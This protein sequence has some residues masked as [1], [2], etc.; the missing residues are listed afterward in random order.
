MSS[1]LKRSSV[2]KDSE[3]GADVDVARGEISP[4]TAAS[5]EEENEFEVF[6]KTKDG[7]DFRTVGWPRAAVI[8]LKVIFATG[9][10][11]IPTAMY[12]LGAVGGALSV[13]GWGILNTYCAM[14]QGDF[15]NTHAGCHTVADMAG[16]VGGAVIKELC[17]VLYLIAYVLC[18]GSGILGVCIG[19]NSLSHHAA[20]SVWWSFLATCVV[21]VCASVRTFQNVGWLTWAGFISIFTA[22]FI[23]VVGVTTRDRPA[24]APQTGPYDLGFHAIAYPT[25]TAGMVASSTIF[26]SSAGTS[27]FMPVIAEMRKPQDYHKALFTCMGFV[28]VSYLT[29]SLVVY[30]WC[31]QWVASPSLGSAG[32]TIKM[33]SYGVGLIGL[34]VSACLYCHVAAKYLFVRILRNS[35]HLQ[36]NSVIHWGTWLS[37]TFGLSAIAFILAEAI[38]IFNYLIALTGSICFAP[39]AITLPGWLWLYDHWDYKSGSLAKKAAWGLH[40]FFV[41]LGLFILVG[42]TYGVVEEIREAYANGEIGMYFLSVLPVRP[43][44]ISLSR[45]RLMIAFQD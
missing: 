35:V 16:I 37:C 11:S 22:V 10:L 25:F 36:K 34:V 44:I 42:G 4:A 29:L 23:V 31:G 9:V 19:I 45:G 21:A 38:P 28:T 39:I 15:R 20:C 14:I 26:V 24:A 5:I 3:K 32:Q 17:G 30:A 8:F 27:A 40:M 33:V 12:S 6:K 43:P 13:I 1:L 18:T 41:V 7:V 2:S